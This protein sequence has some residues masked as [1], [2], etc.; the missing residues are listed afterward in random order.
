[1]KPHD[2]KTGNTI[3]SHYGNHCIVS[4]VIY[5][6]YSKCMQLFVSQNTFHHIPVVRSERLDMTIRRKSIQRLYHCHGSQKKNKRKGKGRQ[7]TVAV[8]VNLKVI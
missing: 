3:K 7:V 1:M 4:V 6:K 5:V 2:A 8:K